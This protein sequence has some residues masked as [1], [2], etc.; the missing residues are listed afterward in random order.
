MTITAE[1]EDCYT[2]EAFFTYGNLLA[3]IPKKLL[4]KNKDGILVA[5]ADL[6]GRIMK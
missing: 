6:S 3:Q 1:D 4:P 5:K 2:V